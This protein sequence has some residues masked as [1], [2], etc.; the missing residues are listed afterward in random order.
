MDIFV[1]IY[2]LLVLTLI[3]TIAGKLVLKFYQSE[4]FGIAL[5]AI[6]GFILLVEA[7]GII[8]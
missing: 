5:V 6:A 8:H 7:S 1:F 4:N 3:L 2:S